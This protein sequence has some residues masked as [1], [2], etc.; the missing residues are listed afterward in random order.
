MDYSKH[1]AVCCLLSFLLEPLMPAPDLEETIP[2]ESEPLLSFLPSG[3]LD[4]EAEVLFLAYVSAPP[5]FPFSCLVTPA[6][7]TFEAC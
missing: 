5:A 1:S 7:L 3:D 2:R 6:L 4:T